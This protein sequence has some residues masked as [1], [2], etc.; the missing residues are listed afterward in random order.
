TQPAA[1]DLSVDLDVSPGKSNNAEEY[2]S[3]T[4]DAR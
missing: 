4:L 1:A 2:D 3:D